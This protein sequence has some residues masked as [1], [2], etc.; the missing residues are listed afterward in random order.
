MNTN[1]RAFSTL[2]FAAFFILILTEING[3]LA[4]YAIH[5]NLDVLLVI[6]C[7]LYLRVLHGWWIILII[8]LSLDAIR[9]IPFGSGVAG[10]I[11]LWVATVWMRGRIRRERPQNCTT[12]AVTIQ[13]IWLLALHL[14]WNEGRWIYAAFWQRLFWD[15]LLSLIVVALLAYP[16]CE[17]Q[18]VFLKWSGWDLNSESNR[19]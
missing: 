8:G 15:T 2:I 18:R 17:F 4:R 13:L 1:V 7:G 11:F 19:V 3:W 16:W 9:P 14:I 12:V 10:L 5:L 6:F